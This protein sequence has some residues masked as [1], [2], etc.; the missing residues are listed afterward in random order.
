MTITYHIPRAGTLGLAILVIIVLALLVMT[1]WMF[2]GRADNPVGAIVGMSV[3]LVVAALFSW[4]LLQQGRSTLLVDRAMLTLSV[5]WY[6]RKVALSDVQID[7]VRVLEPGEDEWSLR[8]RTNGI[9][10]PQ[11]QV[12][13]FRTKGGHKVLAA[14]TQ[15]AR[16]LIP[17]TK[18]FDLLVSLSDAEGFVE[19]CSTRKSET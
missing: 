5:P 14:C 9:G 12:G 4:F 7:Q 19:S 11:Y 8:W 17:T 6:G 13:W 15:G 2:D 18:G 16:V 10:L 1:G 3:T